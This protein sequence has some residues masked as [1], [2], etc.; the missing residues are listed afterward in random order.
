MTTAAR[1]GSLVYRRIV[2]PERVDLKSEDIKPDKIISKSK[3]KVSSG[4][5]GGER[6]KLKEEEEDEEE[7]VVDDENDSDY[8][9]SDSGDS[10]NEDYEGYPTWK[11]RGSDS[12]SAPRQKKATITRDPVAGTRHPASP[13]TVH[14][15]HRTTSLLLPSTERDPTWKAPTTLRQAVIEILRASPG[16]L[17]IESITR[18]L[19]KK[20]DEVPLVTYPAVRRSLYKEAQ[21]KDALVIRIMGLGRPG[22]SQV[23]CYKDHWIER[24]DNV[25]NVPPLSPSSPPPPSPLLCHSP[26]PPPPPP[27]SPAPPP[28]PPP[29]LR[30]SAIT[31]IVATVTASA[32]ITTVSS[33]SH[34]RLEK[35]PP[36]WPAG[37]RA[38]P[39]PPP[40]SKELKGPDCGGG[41]GGGVV[42]LPPPP[43]VSQ[44]TAPPPTTT[45]AAAAAAT[46]P[47]PPT[48]PPPIAPPPTAPPPTTVPPPA[49]TAPT[50]AAK[51]VPTCL[52]AVQPLDLSERVKQLEANDVELRTS[53]DNVRASV[54]ALE[55]EVENLRSVVTGLFGM[56]DKVLMRVP[57][58]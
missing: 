26:I 32:T 5:K 53:L 1:R 55:S 20:K 43:P 28:P 9:N 13:P 17:S 49:A 23:Y 39:A 42:R 46:V 18:R 8:E 31:A 7:Y 30:T 36:A 38:P 44:V 56:I 6:Y 35:R 21:K 51:A 58:R 16:A 15:I 27:L 52:Q 2:R 34:P 12:D 3:E 40:L 54:R 22:H 4:V 19:N 48:A 33:S 37:S 10:D 14:S 57:R 50:T 45:A 41:G 25:E 47:A 29:P 24:T 11:K